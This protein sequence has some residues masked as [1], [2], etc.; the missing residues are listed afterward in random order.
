MDFKILRID[1]ENKKIGLSLR[2]V[3]KDEPIVGGK[4]Q[5]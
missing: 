3:G 2:A 1:L 4:D 5:E